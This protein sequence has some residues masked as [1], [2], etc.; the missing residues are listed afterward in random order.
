MASTLSVSIVSTPTQPGTITGNATPCEGSSQLFSISPV[1]GASSYTWTLPSGWSGS[2]T[3]TSIIATVG[4]NS[5]LIS[6]TAN[7]SCG[8]SA[9]NTLNVSVSGILTQP[10]TIAGNASPC[11][12]STESYSISNVPGASSYTWTLPG[13]WIGYSSTNSIIATVGANSGTI[14]VIA[15]NSC[16]SSNASNLDAS[17]VEVPLQPGTISGNAYP[18]QGA[19]ETYSI[20]DV[21]G[22][23]SYTWTLPGDWT[24]NSSSKSIIATVGANSG[25]ISVIANNSCGS[26]STSTFEVAVIV[27]IANYQVP[28]IRVYPVPNDGIFT[29]EISSQK[30]ETWRI[31]VYNNL[32]IRIL[33]QIH[34]VENGSLKD[35]IDLGNVA[36]GIYT[37][38]VTNDH[39][40]FIE[41]ILILW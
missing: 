5:S 40:K 39:V 31:E 36:S 14:S 27:G 7:N 6:V 1:S 12:G 9:A 13:D 37:I 35:I 28:K 29:V 30:T 17:V 10:G 41:H 32:G 11:N 18:C 34:P 8:S 25:T 3:S 19:T 38:A 23:S 24:G 22:A 15:N 20:S 2:S 26:S 21:P 33:E 16:G 4:A